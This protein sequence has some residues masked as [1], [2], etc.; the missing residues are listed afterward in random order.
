MT[1]GA[2]DCWLQVEGEKYWLAVKWLRNLLYRTE[3]CVELVRA[4]A[5]RLVGDI[6]RLKR[7][8]MS[9]C[10]A[11][12]RAVNFDAARS[13]HAATSLRCQHAV[14][15]H[16]LQRL[17]THPASVVSDLENLLRVMTH[18][19]NLRVHV[20]CDMLSQPDP[21]RPWVWDFQV[22]PHSR[23]PACP[24]VPR[25]VLPSR[26]LRTAEAVSPT[27]CRWSKEADTR[28]SCHVASLLSQRMTPLHQGKGFLL[29][30]TSMDGGYLM[31]CV[32][33]DMSYDDRDYAAVLV[34]DE[35]LMGVEG[36]LWKRIKG[37]NLALGYELTCSPE[38]GLLSFS[39][40]RAA[41]LTAAYSE[42]HEVVMGESSHALGAGLGQLVGGFVHASLPWPPSSLR[43]GCG[44]AGGPGAGGGQELR[45][46]RVP[47]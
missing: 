17:R 20:A 12:M 40:Y 13:N 1:H 37:L 23:D 27:V 32:P 5:Q 2:L 45:H 28:C 47:R 30:S 43:L 36:D 6:A 3:V 26:L 41:D 35:Y 16:V 46:V 24:P 22:V 15:H 10:S 9:M 44:G 31:Q 14:L 42:A 25:P 18:P 11:L 39:I 34:A 29:S 8:G 21:V 4:A 33:V 7:D 38:Q 19:D